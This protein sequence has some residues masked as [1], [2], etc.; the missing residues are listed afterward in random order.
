M[1]RHIQMEEL[2]PRIF[3]TTRREI[4]LFMVAVIVGCI[5]SVASVVMWGYT[6]ATQR[7]NWNCADNG[8]RFEA[9]YNTQDLT[10]TMMKE[11]GDSFAYSSDKLSAMRLCRRQVYLH[12][13][14]TYCGVTVKNNTRS[15]DGPETED[16]H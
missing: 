9:R 1:G 2:D 7:D 4:Y 15:T 10:P 14:C 11:I 13:V 8:H 3:A 12:D 16:H 5:F 6:A